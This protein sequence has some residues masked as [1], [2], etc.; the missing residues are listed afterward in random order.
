MDK[1]P[2]CQA[3]F[4]NAADHLAVSDVSRCSLELYNMI[5]PFE[6]DD[7]KHLM[8]SWEASPRHL[9]LT[10]G[11]E[12]AR[13]QSTIRWNS[14]DMTANIEELLKMGSLAVCIS[15]IL[16]REIFS[17]CEFEISNSIKKISSLSLICACDHL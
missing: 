11:L 2:L 7:Q 16:K 12:N 8:Y 1:W 15:I 5:W 3:E 17:N 14:K 6:F 9:E 10:H 13:E 4:T